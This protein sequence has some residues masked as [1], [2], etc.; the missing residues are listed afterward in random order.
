MGVDLIDAPSEHAQAVLDS[1]EPNICEAEVAECDLILE[2]G[3]DILYGRENGAYVEQ[4]L[5]ERSGYSEAE[6]LTVDPVDAPGGYTEAGLDKN[7]PHIC[8]A[9]VA[10]HCSDEECKGNIL[11]EGNYNADVERGSVD[12]EMF[13]DSEVERGSVDS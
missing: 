9:E 11:N 3:D 1:N 2:Y 6:Q 12:G 7:D 13:S 8:E 4:D 10:E 5:G